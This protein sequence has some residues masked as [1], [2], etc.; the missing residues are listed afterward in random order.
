MPR[1]ITTG[2]CGGPTSHVRGALIIRAGARA[3][4]CCPMHGEAGRHR[5]RLVLAQHD[6]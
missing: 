6:A 2:P 3:G 4:V 1:F 5:F